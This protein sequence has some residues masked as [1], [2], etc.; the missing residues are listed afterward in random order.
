MPA[1]ASFARPSVQYARLPY[2]G[3]PWPPRAIQWFSGARACPDIRRLLPLF[4]TRALE[5]SIAPPGPVLPPCF[6]TRP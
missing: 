4:G 6:F 5:L 2:A 1:Y 3:P